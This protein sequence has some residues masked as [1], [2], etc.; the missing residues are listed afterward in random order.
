MAP[1]H[2]LY[3]PRSISIPLALV[4]IAQPVVNAIVDASMPHIAGACTSVCWGL[5]ATAPR[6][7]LEE[8]GLDRRSLVATAIGGVF[9]L[10]TLFLT[11]G[12]GYP[13]V[14]GAMTVAGIHLPWRWAVGGVS[15]LATA[16]WVRLTSDMTG[17]ERLLAAFGF[18]ALSFSFLGLARLV[19]RTL[20]EHRKVQV[21]G[22]ELH[23]ANELLRVQAAEREA[24]ARQRER[25]RIAQ[26]L[27]DSLGHILTAMH[28]QLEL[29]QQ[30]DDLGPAIEKARML[31]QEGLTA[32]RQSVSVLREDRPTPSLERALRELID[33]LPGGTPEVG[34]NVQG[35]ARTL[36]AATSYAF[37]RAAQEALTNALRHASAAHVIV[38]LDYREP[39]RVRL[40][41]ADDGVGASE[42]DAGAGLSGL[43]ERVEAVGGAAFTQTKPGGGFQLEVRIP[44]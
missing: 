40:M 28:L 19:R 17:V 34:L 30:S 20:H 14:F 15:V 32:L 33:D 10:A 26:D 4:T 21:L 8:E 1:R 35:A 44:S 27:H 18:L 42:V 12:N 31:T 39:Q 3:I 13:V 9:A 5:V 2:G 29:A 38:E 43:R 22:Q 24:W 37:Y 23:D 41:V 36:P 6:L 16:T 7:D 11:M 25:T